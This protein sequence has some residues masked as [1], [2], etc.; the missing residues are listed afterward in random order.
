MKL[1]FHRAENIAVTATKSAD[2]AAAHASAEPSTDPPRQVTSRTTGMPTAPTNMTI[3]AHHGI[4]RVHLALSLVG[5]LCLPAL[6]APSSLGCLIE[7]ERTADVGSPVIGVVERIEVERGDR[8]SKGQVLAVL[9][10]GVERAALKVATTRAES[11]ADLKAAAAS[12]EFNR[13]KLE[14][15]RDLFQK[16]FVAQQA[17][18]QARAEADLAD[19]KLVQTREQR[20]LARQERD[21]AAAQLAL[22]VIRSPI[23]GVVAERYVWPGER[24]DDKPLLRIAKVDPLRVQLVVPVSMY[25]QVQLGGLASVMPEFPGAT[26]LSARVTM[27]DKVADPASNTFRVHL[28]MPNRDAALPAGLRCKADFGAGPAPQNPTLPSNAVNAAG[29][30][31][32]VAA[33]AGA[34][35]VQAAGQP[36]HAAVPAIAAAP[37]PARVQQG[38]VI[39]ASAN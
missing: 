29:A 7:A 25:S 10:S 38:R 33:T 28:E 26:A 4:K 1:I 39:E 9:K 14:R 24:V 6:A 16:E 30:V 11:D 5:L 23:D 32:P 20:G 15:T 13:K 34:T 36:A 31:V 37:T 19:Q 3:A 12:A 21:L 17:V 27:I 18:D 35:S 2:E 8:V 22:R